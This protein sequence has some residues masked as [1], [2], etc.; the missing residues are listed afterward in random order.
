MADTDLDPARASPSS[1]VQEHRCSL[2]RNCLWLLYHERIQ[3]KK[4]AQRRRRRNNEGKG[5]T[6]RIATL[7]VGS[8]TGRGQEVMDFMERRK[9]NIMCIQETKWKGSK[10]RELGNGFKLFYIGEDGRRNGVGYYSQ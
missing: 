7:N 4:I 2:A 10:A 8:M 6:I 5:K 1:D 3:L 9:I